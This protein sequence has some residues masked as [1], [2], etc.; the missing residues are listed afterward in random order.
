MLNVGRTAI[1]KT[2]PRP[3]WKVD[4]K[5]ASDEVLRHGGFETEWIDGV[6]VLV[7]DESGNR[8]LATN[9]PG[10]YPI[11]YEVPIHDPHLQRAILRPHSEWLIEPERVVATYDVV[12][13]PLNEAIEKARQAAFKRINAEYESHALTLVEG[14]PTSEQQSWPV[15]IREAEILL[16]ADDEPTPWIDAAA[17][18]RGISRVE[19]ANLIKAQDT[20]YRQYHGTLTGIRQALRDQIAA[21]SDDDPAPVAALYEIA[22]PESEPQT[23]TT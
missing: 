3:N 12:D 15:Q 23:E 21:I 16:G 2:G 13:I 6:E 18:A 19:L 14:Y 22:W 1:L 5:P 11:A 7:L 8:I 20:A 10:W 9:K 17:S 4:G